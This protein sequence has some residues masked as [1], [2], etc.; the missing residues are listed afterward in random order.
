M[1]KTDEGSHVVRLRFTCLQPPE[2][3]EQ[4][5]I[6]FGL[7][8]RRMDMAGSSRGDLITGR[9]GLVRPAGPERLPTLGKL[10]VLDH[11][12][13]ESREP[14]SPVTTSSPFANRYSL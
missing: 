3:P 11:S 5:P 10:C 13:S 12:L 6:V 7:Q 2:R 1:G 9:E 14:K 8:D 4:G